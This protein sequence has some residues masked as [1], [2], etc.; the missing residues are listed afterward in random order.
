MSNAVVKRAETGIV[1][2]E[3][4]RDIVDLVLDSL[5]SVASRRIYGKA[6]SDF[7]AWHAERGQ[8]TLS[9]A[10]VQDFR[11]ELIDSGLA[12]A[13]INQRLS[14]I[15]SLAREALDNDLIP[16]TLAHGIENV[17]GVKSAGQRLGNWLTKAQAL[18]LL[19]TPDTG[20]LKGKRDRA[21]LAVMLGCGLRRSE[22]ANLTVSH[23]QEREGR[24]II[25]DLIGKRNRVRT[26]PMPTWAKEMIDAWT[27]AAG[28]TQGRVFRSI[29]K[30]GNLSGPSMTPQAVFY[31]VKGYGEK[32]I[33]GLAPHD[34]R[35][36]FAKLSHRGGANL[37]QIQLSL[38]HKTIQTTEAYVNADQAMQEG[39]APCD[40]LGLG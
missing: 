36:T 29:N 31:L 38:G 18:L 11:S 9:K 28:I 1:G 23:I 37:K 5:D 40:F 4:Y 8:P 14:A 32:I 27:L 22:V 26:V 20:T 34:L 39:Q 17:K 6:L 7:L 13:T 12:P 25:A 15:R 33:P 3:E 24:W 21:I 2:A 35:R 30:G 19:D 10:L 16:A